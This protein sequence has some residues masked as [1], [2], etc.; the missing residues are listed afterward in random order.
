[1]KGHE[2]D[3]KEGFEGYF[4]LWCDCGSWVDLEEDA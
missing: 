4:F 2:H 3:W 1:M